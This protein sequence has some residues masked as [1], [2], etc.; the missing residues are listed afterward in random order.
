[1]RAWRRSPAGLGRSFETA[2]PVCPSTNAFL[3]PTMNFLAK[4]LRIMH[5]TKH[6]DLAYD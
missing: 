6:M 4:I 5:V 1:L 3:V 2:H